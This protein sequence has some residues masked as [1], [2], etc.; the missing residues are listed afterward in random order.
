MIK[1]IHHIAIKAKSSEYEKLV[2]FYE[3]LLGMKR[4]RSW[5]GGVMLSTGD[6]SV[7]E[8]MCD[9]NVTITNDGA[10]RHIAFTTDLVDELIEKIKENGFE[11]IDEPK[12]ITIQA[13][14]PYPVRIA[15]CKGVVGEV[16]EFFKEY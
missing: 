15:F 7:M 13:E 5:N 2:W 6:N 12:D 3:D 9:D 4:V 16:I 8:L 10:L 14:Q 1:G 11:V